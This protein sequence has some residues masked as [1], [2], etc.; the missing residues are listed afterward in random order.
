MIKILQEICELSL[1]QRNIFYNMTIDA[2]PDYPY[3]R[4]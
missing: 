2:Y 3:N 1:F 4:I